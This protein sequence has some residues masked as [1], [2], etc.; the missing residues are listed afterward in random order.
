MGAVRA[1]LKLPVFVY[2]LHLGFLL[3]ERFLLLEHRGRR[4]GRTYRAV[5]EVVRVDREDGEV[6]V[7]SGWGRRANW[8]RNVIAGGA[9]GV[10]VGRRRFAPEVRLLGVDEA[11]SALAAYERRNRIAAPLIRRVLSR[12][13]GFPYDGS[14]EGRRRIVQELPLV[15]FRPRP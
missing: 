6:V 12:L 14:R 3:G 9:L 8:L 15:G 10:Q 13:A 5:L 2:R 4:S 1:V 11:S 7:M